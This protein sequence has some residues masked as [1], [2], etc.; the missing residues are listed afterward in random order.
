MKKSEMLTCAGPARG[1]CGHNHRSFNT[2]VRCCLRDTAA[3]N[4]QGG[5]S[6]R[7]PV[8]ING[9]DFNDEEIEYIG[10]LFTR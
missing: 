3:C 5:Y 2:A 8:R 10:E 6:D 4:R 1:N 9:E 7:Y